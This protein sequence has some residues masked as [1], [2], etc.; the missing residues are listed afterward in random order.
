MELNRMPITP[1]CP[2]HLTLINLE[3]NRIYKESDHLQV[4]EQIIRPLFNASTEVYIYK[5]TTRERMTSEGYIKPIELKNKSILK[6]K[7]GKYIFDKTQECIIG[8]EYLW[9]VTGSIR[10]SIVF[11]L[12]NN[13]DFSGVFKYCYTP[14]ILSNPTTGQSQGAIRL[15]RKMIEENRV[16]ALLSASNGIEKMD[17][18]APTETFKKIKNLAYFLCKS[19]DDRNKEPFSQIMNES[20]IDCSG[21]ANGSEAETNRN[22]V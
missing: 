7:N 5:G 21:I 10:G 2:L 4:H 16:T 18:C 14:C 11:V 1:F 20:T 13:F 8:H 3:T 15:C 6:P 22:A 19:W 17:I 9:N 12:E